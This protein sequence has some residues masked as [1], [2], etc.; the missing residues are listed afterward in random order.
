MRQDVHTKFLV[1]LGII[2][3]VIGGVIV[4]FI[5]SSGPHEDTRE[6]RNVGGLTCV[7]NVDTD[8]MEACAPTA[9]SLP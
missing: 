2:F 9:T 7:Y 3:F 4:Y 8:E 6:I 1:L 5:T